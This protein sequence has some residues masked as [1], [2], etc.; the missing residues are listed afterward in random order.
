MSQHKD[1]ANDD[2]GSDEALL[3]LARRI[4]RAAPWR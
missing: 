3:D 1:N 2:V 4:A